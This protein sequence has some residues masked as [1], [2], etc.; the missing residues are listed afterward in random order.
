MSKSLLS[1]QITIVLYLLAAALSSVEAVYQFQRGGWKNPWV[2]V[3]AG[4]FFLSA[5]MY[6]IR[7]KQRIESRINL[8]REE[9]NQEDK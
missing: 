9:D 7:K 8:K 3:L 5:V 6:F 1:Q 4:V 2:Y